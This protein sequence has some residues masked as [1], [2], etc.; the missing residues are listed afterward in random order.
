[1]TTFELSYLCLEPFLSA[2]YRQVRRRLLRVTRCCARPAR[3]L[4]VGGRKSHYTIGLRAGICVT[5]LPRE[6]AL[7]ERLHL[8]MNSEIACQLQRRRSNV[9]A[10]V[11]DDMTRSSLKA[12]TFDCV[13]AV[14]V[15]EHVE[16]DERF[17]EEVYRVLKPEGVFLLT[18]PN[19]ATVRNTNPDHKRHYTREELRA[20]LASRFRDV[21]VEHA[22]RGGRFYQW[23]V[24]AWSVKRPFR[25]TLSMAANVVNVV[26]SGGEA[27]RH[28]SQGT[29]HLIAEARKAG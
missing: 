17:V 16:R 4:D 25:T 29:L 18:T 10:V 22:I 20:L 1:M 15:L 5:D 26:Q 3:V 13:V 11:Y 19:G 28:Q 2:L 9:Q 6:S 27:I 21:R 14:E 12:A 23:G 24:K 7:Q 8:G